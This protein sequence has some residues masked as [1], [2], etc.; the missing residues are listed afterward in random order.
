MD[1]FTILS[2]PEVHTLAGEVETLYARTWKASNPAE[3]K[4]PPRQQVWA[5]TAF[6]AATA[7][8]NDFPRVRAV[9]ISEYCKRDDRPDGLFSARM[10]FGGMTPYTDA[11][12]S[13][14]ANDGGPALAAAIC[15]Q[16]NA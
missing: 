16:L 1:T 13:K 10:A 11:R 3:K 7:F 9:T 2:P 15:A 5:K 4:W 8:K 14:L 6:E 12:Y